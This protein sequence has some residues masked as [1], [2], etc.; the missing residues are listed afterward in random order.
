[1]KAGGDLGIMTEDG[2]VAMS[3]IEKL[4]QVSLQNS[5]ITFPIAPSWRDAVT[6]RSGLSG[7]QIVIWPMRS[8]AVVNL[9]KMSASDKTQVVDNARTGAWCRYTGWDANCFVVSGLSENN[10]QLFYGTSDGRTMLAETGGLDDGAAYTTTI[11]P[12][13]EHL[14]ALETAVTQATSYSAVTNRQLKM[15]RPNLFTDTNF[16]PKLTCKVDYDTD[17][18]HFPGTSYL[19][20]TGAQWDVAVWDVDVWPPTLSKQ[21]I[22]R[23]CPG[24]GAVHSPVMQWT[25]S[26]VAPPDIRLTA[27]DLIWESGSLLG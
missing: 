22:W 4:D 11:F 23:S 19:P 6:S 12:R 14:S 9:P 18:P 24:Y 8:M 27:F 3:Q 13:F 25:V 15:V 2:I 10:S 16:L 5:A 20:V 26:Q 17:I 7:W 1:M 21:I